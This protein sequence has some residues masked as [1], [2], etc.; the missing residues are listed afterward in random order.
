ME[1]LSV[2]SAF[3]GDDIRL[4]S[5]F[6]CPFLSVTVAFVL[7]NNTRRCAA[8]LIGKDEAVGNAGD[9]ERFTHTAK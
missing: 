5:R 6:D 4:I 8:W 2:G 1:I 7:D 9:V 3:Q